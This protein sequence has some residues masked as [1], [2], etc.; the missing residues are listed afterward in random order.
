MTTDI[1]P[2]PAVSARIL[3]DRSG[4]MASMWAEAM[5]AINT[6]AGT[7]AKEQPG[8]EVALTV[9]DGSGG[10]TDVVTIRQSRADAWVDLTGTEAPP[11]GMTPLYDAIVTFVAQ[12]ESRGAS[13]TTLI[14]MTDGGENAS[15]EANSLTAKAALDRAR[16]KGWDVVFLGAN[17]D[18]FGQAAAVGTMAANTLNMATGSIVASM[19]GLGVRTAAYS[20]GD[21]A[22]GAAFSDEDRKRAAGQL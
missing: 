8:A 7:L 14:I 20:K 16:A 9:F 22:A 12:A 6:Y 1:S 10:R 11:R 17:W 19:A 13:K 5:G 4:S 3:L 2:T 21:L 18:A 15:R